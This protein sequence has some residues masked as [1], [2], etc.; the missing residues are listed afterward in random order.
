[1]GSIRR[2]WALITTMMDSS[3][4]FLQNA[5]S[6]QFVGSSSSCDRPRRTGAYRRLSYNRIFAGPPSQYEHTPDLIFQFKASTSFDPDHEFGGL[7]PNF[8]FSSS[9]SH[10]PHGMVPDIVSWCKLIMVR[11]EGRPV[12]GRALGRYISIHRL[13]LSFL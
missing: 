9:S 5:Q 1:M 4:S 12:W 8:T 11:S 2:C 7:L 6:L 13:P 10:S 3:I